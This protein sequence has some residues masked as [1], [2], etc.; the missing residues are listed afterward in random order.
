MGKSNAD[1][2]N[3]RQMPQVHYIYKVIKETFRKQVNVVENS[4]YVM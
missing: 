1:W 3:S 4:L 2:T